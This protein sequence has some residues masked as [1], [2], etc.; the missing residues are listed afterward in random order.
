MR[1]QSILR[2]KELSFVLC[3][4]SAVIAFAEDPPPAASGLEAPNA[5]QILDRYV[6][7]TGGREA[8]EKLKNIVIEKS[9]EIEIMG[10][11]MDGKVYMAPP[12]KLY[13]EFNN[14]RAGLMRSGTDGETA[15]QINA[16][17]GAR[18]LTGKDKKQI[19]RLAMFNPDLNWAKYYKS[20]EV[21]GLEEVQEQP[22]YKVRLTDNDGNQEIRYYNVES[23]LLI[24][25]TLLKPNSGNDLHTLYEDYK[26]VDGLLFAH[27]LRQYAT[28]QETVHTIHKIVLNADLPEDRFELPDQIKALGQDQAS[29]KQ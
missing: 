18:L 15:W 25:S 20:A 1:Q 28:S 2:W 22:C 29:S 9:I 11:K 24:K 10:L 21:D 26:K 14:D 3:C 8:Y 4:V 13:Q 16:V 17:A 7:V 5:K 19:E 23:G 12:N 27:R 6:E